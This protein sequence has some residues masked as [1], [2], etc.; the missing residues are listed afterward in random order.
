MKAI[1][2]PIGAAY[3]HVEDEDV[4]V[5]VNAESFIR[6]KEVVCL[7]LKDMRLYFTPDNSYVE[8]VNFEEENDA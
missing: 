6:D 8:L 3:R 7:C 2:V 5:R 4:F 1:E